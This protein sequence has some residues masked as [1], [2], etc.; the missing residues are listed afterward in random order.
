MQYMV[1]KYFEYLSRLAGTKCYH[2]L[3]QSGHAKH[4]RTSERNIRVP[5]SNV[6]A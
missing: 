2:A 3:L 5:V 1:V 4:S 6:T